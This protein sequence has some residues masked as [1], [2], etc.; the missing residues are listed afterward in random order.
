M[1]HPLTRHA[2]PAHP[3]LTLAWRTLGGSGAPPP[4]DTFLSAVTERFGPPSVT[5][6]FHA[7]NAVLAAAGWEL[8][9]D[10]SL[11]WERHVKGVVWA[12]F[13]YN[14]YGDIPDSHVEVGC[15]RKWYGNV[16]DG[17]AAHLAAAVDPASSADSLRAAYASHPWVAAIVTANPSV[18]GD[19]AAYDALRC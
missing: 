19:I 14:V 3:D 7:V 15:D 18:P 2:P 16:P 6:T 12:V 9:A 17:C 13:F 8:V 11:H 10:E 5:A 1:D 4:L